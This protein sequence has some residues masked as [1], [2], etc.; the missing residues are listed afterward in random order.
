MT[1]PFNPQRAFGEGCCVINLLAEL[2]GQ[3][4]VVSALDDHDRRGDVFQFG[5]GVELRVN[6]KVHA[7]KKPK[8]FAGRSGRG[9][10]GCLEDEATNLAV[11][12]EVGCYGR[13]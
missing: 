5:N 9:G 10:K 13:S 4:G 3:D 12:S 11:G 6:E 1:I 7:G 2:E 8:Q